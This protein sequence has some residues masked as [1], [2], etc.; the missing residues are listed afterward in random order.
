MGKMTMN[1]GNGACAKVKYAGRRG[2]EMG[3]VKGMAREEAGPP[4]LNSSG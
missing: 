1:R 4:H 2:R 3:D